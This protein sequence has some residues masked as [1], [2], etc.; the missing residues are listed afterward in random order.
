MKYF[1][2]SAVLAGILTL[3]C[4]GGSYNH[5]NYSPSSSSYNYLPQ[6]GSAVP[7]NQPYPDMFFKNYGVNAFIDTEDDN[8]STFGIDVDKA[9]Y[10]I[11]RRY[12]QDGNL[13]PEESVRTEEFI[14]YFKYNYPTPENGNPIGICIE[15]TPSRFGRNCVML[16]VGIQAKEIRESRRKNAVL[17]F[18]IDTSG[19]METENRLELVKKCLRML[20]DNLEEYDRVAIVVYHSNT[21]VIL[22]HTGLEDK[23]EILKAIKR[24]SP[25][26]S[27]YAEAG[28]KIG[29]K[30]ASEN[31]KK[32]CINRVIL[33]SDGVANVGQT[34]AG[35]ILKEIRRYAKK[36][37]YLSTFGFGM[38]NYND[39]LMEQLADKGNGSYAYIDDIDEARRVFTDSMA[40]LLQVVAK[41]VKVQVEF[42]PETVRS[43]RLI[44]YENRDIKDENFR[45]EEQDAGEMNSGQAATALYEIKLWKDRSGRAVKVRVNYKNPA[46]EETD[47]L[48]ESFSTDDFAESFE[49]A[50]DSFKLAAAAAEFAEILRKSQWAKANNIEKV[51]SLTK[52]LRDNSEYEND[53]KVAELTEL[54]SKASKLI[55]HNEPESD[56]ESAT[57]K[58][59]PKDSKWREENTI[60]G[61]NNAL[62]KER[63]TITGLE[64]KAI[65][66]YNE[67]KIRESEELTKKLIKSKANYRTI[68]N[69]LNELIQT[70]NT[71][72]KNSGLRSKLN[73]AAGPEYTLFD[74]NLD[75]NNAF[76]GKMQ[77]GY[78]TKSIYRESDFMQMQN[79]F[80]D[81]QIYWNNIMPYIKFSG[82]ATNTE[83]GH[84][85]IGVNSFSAGFC[86][87]RSAYGDT[88]NFGGS[89]AAGIKNFSGKDYND[90]SPFA[91]IGYISKH[92]YSDKAESTFLIGTE[93]VLSSAPDGDTRT[94]WNFICSFC[95]ELYF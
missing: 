58:D 4:Q 45:D 35:E 69:E 42:N 23:D 28:L 52:K 27:T 16:K 51:I 40:E 60:T 10:A 59:C 84:R 26:G 5:A 9:S 68:D 48:S 22:E 49:D 75:I 61:Q 72:L 70:Q 88:N 24:L 74:H 86:G 64:Q 95:F 39:I 73:F 50:S 33:C 32:D 7:N 93:S 71:Y 79:E 37:I 18:V 15:G 19:S 30:L 29:Y 8:L 12:I 21:E 63:S 62:S 66:L 90:L 53:D 55:K 41:D 34:G 94:Y 65:A 13:P 11:T 17:T 31:Y 67:G 54:A 57:T 1:L 25:G 80:A 91:E 47:E 56:E 76:G 44:G 77:I 43:Y 81:R 14:N 36:G 83:K 82:L 92:I 46:D 20:V 6:G 87:T 38:G 85:D 78:S 2:L 89:I 3:G